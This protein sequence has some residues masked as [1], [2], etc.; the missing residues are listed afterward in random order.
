LVKLILNVIVS[1]FARTS[2][3]ILPYLYI[4]VFT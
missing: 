1:Q 4:Y 2:L 3:L